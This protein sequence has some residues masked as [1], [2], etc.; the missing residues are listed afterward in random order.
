LCVCRTARADPLDGIDVRWT[1]LDSCVDHGEVAA[2]ARRLLPADGAYEPT[3]IVIDVQV[4]PPPAVGYRIELSA[5][6]ASR[7]AERTLVLASC[8]EARTA[9]GLLI[10]LALDPGAVV[11]A[12]A[13]EPPSDATVAPPADATTAAPPAPIAPAPRAKAPIV[14]PASFALGPELAAGVVIDSS[15]LPDLALGPFVAVGARIGL[16]RVALGGSYLPG[17][18][19]GVAGD[20][21][22]HATLLAGQ[23]GTCV[24]WALDSGFEAGACAGAELGR[25][26]ARA[27][28]VTHGRS[29]ATLWSAASVGAAAALGLSARVALVGSVSLLAPFSRPVLGLLE[30]DAAYVVPA[31]SLRGTLGVRWF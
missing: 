16:L 6:S 26:A 22:I 19:R 13:L 18:E 12:D 20:G 24:L 1:G 31:A 3:Q 21:S 25:Y 2:E 15:V 23:L 7:S 30:M 10:A 11:A 5:R 4:L 14:R 28:G 9:A 8:D 17:A 27:R 29:D